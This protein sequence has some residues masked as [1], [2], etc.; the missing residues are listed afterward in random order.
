MQALADAVGLRMLGFRPR[1][2][3]VLYRQIEL[4]FVMLTLAAVFRS[5]IRQDAQQ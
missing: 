4:V 2:I 1:V 5:S 3:D